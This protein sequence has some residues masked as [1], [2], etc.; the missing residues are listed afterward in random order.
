M[1]HLGIFKTNSRENSICP[2]VLVYGW[3]RM[4]T[5]KFLHFIFSSPSL[6]KHVRHYDPAFTVSF[7]FLSVISWSSE[8]EASWNHHKDTALSAH[9]LR[10][11]PEGPVSPLGVQD[12]LPQTPSEAGD[13]PWAPVGHG[14]NP[15]V[16]GRAVAGP[17]GTWRGWSSAPGSWCCIQPGFPAPHSLSHKDTMRRIRYMR[18]R[19][20][21]A[22]LWYRSA[23]CRDCEISFSHTPHAGA[24]ATGEGCDKHDAFISSYSAGFNSG[25]LGVCVS[26]YSSMLSVAPP[27]F[28]LKFSK[29]Y[30]LRKDWFALIRRKR[31]DEKE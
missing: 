5:Y 18:L 29:V 9:W 16:Q 4:L 21:R 8:L 11:E 26:F 24:L 2:S 10:S 22:A 3:R 19:E 23:T 13:S 1:W 6:L 20:S 28:C 25:K 27:H 17:A 31:K 14:W 7:L 30:S 12:S 15:G